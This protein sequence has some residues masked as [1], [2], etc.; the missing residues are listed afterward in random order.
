MGG[1]AELPLAVIAKPADS[2][3]P[4]CR[5]R[6]NRDDG[7]RLLEARGLC[8]PLIFG[9]VARGEDNADSDIDLLV[10][11]DRPL[12]LLALVRVEAELSELLGVPA[13]LVLAHTIRPDL[14]DSIRREAIEL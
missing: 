4:G 13:D 9:S 10:H 11:A 5:L 6:E 3:R 8:N 2:H 1:G 7:L 14:A 12:G